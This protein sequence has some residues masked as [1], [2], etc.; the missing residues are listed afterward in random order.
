[1][2][3]QWITTCGGNGYWRLSLNGITITCDDS[4]LNDAIDELN[5]IVEERAQNEN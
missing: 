2:S 3:K 4:E 1:M 5:A